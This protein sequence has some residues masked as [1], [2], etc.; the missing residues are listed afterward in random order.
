VIQRFLLIFALLG[1]AIAVAKSYNVTLFQPATVGNVQLAAGD[2]RL[3]VVGQKLVIRSGK[4]VA[5]C[6]VKEETGETRY[7]TTTV[8]F[9]NSEGKMRIQEVHLGGTA[10]KLVLTASSAN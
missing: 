2:Y 3:D 5:E 8:R 9:D 4:V 6:P 10:T 7:L 1:T